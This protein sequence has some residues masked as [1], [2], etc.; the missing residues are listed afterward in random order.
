MRIQEI[1]VRDAIRAK[2][3]ELGIDVAVVKNL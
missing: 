3:I 2:A 1:R